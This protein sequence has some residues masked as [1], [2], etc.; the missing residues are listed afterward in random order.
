[1]LIRFDFRRWRIGVR[2]GTYVSG[3]QVLADICTRS[4]LLRFADTLGLRPHP[5]NDNQSLAADVWCAAERRQA[6]RRR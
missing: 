3:P 2:A 1:M 4:Q 5:K 6:G